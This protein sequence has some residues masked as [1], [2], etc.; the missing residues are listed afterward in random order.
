MCDDHLQ[1]VLAAVQHNRT[2]HCDVR[3]CPG[4]L[5]SCFHAGSCM[6]RSGFVE[7]A[8]RDCGTCDPQLVPE[9]VSNVSR[10][11]KNAEVPKDGGTV[12]PQ[13]RGASG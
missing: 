5:H 10:I 9:T 4:L 1:I 12:A 3:Q 2:G 7:S 6:K 13:C 11:A 8:G